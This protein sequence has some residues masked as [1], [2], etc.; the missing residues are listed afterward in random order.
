MVAVAISNIDKSMLRLL[1]AERLLVF[2]R[3]SFNAFFSRFSRFSSVWGCMLC[4]P[5]NVR[6]LVV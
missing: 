1:K 4:A 3:V 2:L 5:M 6:I